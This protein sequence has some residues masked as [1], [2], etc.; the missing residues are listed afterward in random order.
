[1]GK[2]QLITCLS[3]AATVWVIHSAALHLKPHP[4]H[5]VLSSTKFETLRTLRGGNNNQCCLTIDNP[6]TCILV[7]Q[8]I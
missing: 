4:H 3:V 2:S 6:C 1:M 5:L 7:W 8:S